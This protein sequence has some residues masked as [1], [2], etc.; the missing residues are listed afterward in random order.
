MLSLFVWHTTQHT[1]R[2]GTH[3]GA[4][5]VTGLTVLA[6]ARGWVA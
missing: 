1:H 6:V 4:W 5:L 3:P 2:D